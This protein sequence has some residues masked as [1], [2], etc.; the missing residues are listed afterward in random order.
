VPDLKDEDIE[1]DHESLE[2]EDDCNYSYVAESGVPSFGIV[3]R[4]MKI[5]LKICPYLA[6]IIHWHLK[7]T[8]F[9]LKVNFILNLPAKRQQV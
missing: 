3:G 8:P 5:L 9:A 2:Y 4:K 1:E 7:L 6:W